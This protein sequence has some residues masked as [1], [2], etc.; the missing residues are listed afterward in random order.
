M[1]DLVQQVV[2]VQQVSLQTLLHRT[3]PEAQVVGLE[4]LGALALEVVNPAILQTT[5]TQPG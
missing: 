4:G 5:G 2:I 3:V 1:H